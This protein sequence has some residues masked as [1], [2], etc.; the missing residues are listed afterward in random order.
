MQG[1]PTAAPAEAPRAGRKG[2]LSGAIRPWPIYHEGTE[3]ACLDATL[4]Q[5]YTL[6]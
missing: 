6:T 4:P 3:G 2:T 5:A 1:G